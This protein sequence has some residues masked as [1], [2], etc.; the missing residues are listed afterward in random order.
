MVTRV[1]LQRMVNPTSAVSDLDRLI[2]EGYEENNAATDWVYLNNAVIKASSQFTVEGQSDLKVLPFL[3]FAGFNLVD[4]KGRTLVLDRPLELPNSSGFGIMNGCLTVTDDF[5]EDEYI[6]KTSSGT[7]DLDLH[8]FALIN[9]TLHGKRRANLIELNNF[10]DCHIVN[11][12]GYA[13]NSVG[14]HAS[15][16]AVSH[17][18]YVTGGKWEKNTFRDNQAGLDNTGVVFLVDAFDCDFR[19]A[20]VGGATEA[21]VFGRNSAAQFCSIEGVHIATGIGLE[22]GILVH[23]NSI[24]GF[25]ACGN[26]I[27]GCQVILE[28]CTGAT[29]NRNRF[30]NS[31]TTRP[32][33][34]FV[35]LRPT[36]G[37]QTL[38][39]FTAK[40]N[41]FISNGNQFTAFFI[42]T[43]SGTFSSIN[44]G[45]SIDS[46]SR[47][48]SV[49]LRQL[50]V[51]GGRFVSSGTQAVFDFDEDLLLPPNYVQAGIR[52]ASFATA[53]VTTASIS[54]TT[55]TVDLSSTITGSVDVEVRRRG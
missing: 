49:I 54:G 40:S 20:F 24:Q 33:G 21:F 45:T 48:G 16:A 12:S 4:L 55:V 31:S 41:K 8:K 27:D 46:N 18:L 2:A 34:N 44:N 38:S 28:N 39:D 50:V 25:S 1:S 17:E 52:D 42:D 43:A 5:P 51:T 7:E 14:V 30:L 53:P 32:S 29:L 35:E 26:Y 3:P 11:S 37:G 13:F 47:N 22:T 15:G 6:I 19:P 36:V 23:Q 9:V 10:L